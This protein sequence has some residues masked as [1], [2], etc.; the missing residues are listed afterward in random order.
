MKQFFFFLLV[1]VKAFSQGPDFI[2]IGVAKG[3][4]TSLYDYLNSHPK[5][6][7]PQKKELHFF[8]ERFNEGVKAY[9]E[10]FPKKN[11]Q[12][13]PLSGDV[14]PRYFVRDFVPGRV[15]QL[16]PEVK[17]ILLLRNPVERAFSHYKQHLFTK[18]GRSFE[19]HL[20][21]EFKLL[22]DENNEVD[23]PLL[24]RG[25]YAHH[26]E[27]WLKKFPK[28]QILILIS[29]DFFKNTQE[30]MDRIYEFLQLPPY[31]HASFPIKNEGVNKE[32]VL[33][34]ATRVV[35]ERF[36]R[37]HNQRLQKLLD[38]EGFDITLNWDK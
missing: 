4:T 23:L 18:S 11:S 10:K 2:V 8:D 34:K 31:K 24:Q 6:Q 33:N 35:L 27:Q 15:K 22:F 7:M 20:N 3:G 1:F 14:T 16:F 38:E 5:I 12:G 36:Y 28:E 9:N 19:E 26:L 37:S 25:F 17:L 32:L 13:F 30:T 29:E 21:D